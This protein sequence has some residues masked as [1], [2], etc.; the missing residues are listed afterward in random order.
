M[1]PGALM[2][3]LVRRVL[4]LLC[5][6]LV[7]FIAPAAIAQPS[8]PD[9]P[10]DVEESVPEDVDEDAPDEDSR[11]DG[12]ARL[13]DAGEPDLPEAPR[14]PEAVDEPDSEDR[15]IMAD[16]N[17]PPGANDPCDEE[18]P[19]RPVV[20]VHGTFE[21]AQSSWS[22]LTPVL[23]RAEYCVFT[24]DYGENERGFQGTEEIED[25]AAELEDFIEGD[26]GVLDRTG[27]DEVQIVGHSQGGLMPR[28]YVKELGG[29]DVVDD[30]IG[31][32]SSNHG[33]DNPFAPPAG[34]LGG[35]PACDQ[36]FPYQFSDDGNEFTEE[37]NTG[38]ETP[39]DVSYTQI[40]SRFDEIILPYFSTF[41][42]DEDAGDEPPAN[43]PLTAELDGDGTT[44]VCL[45]DMFPNN[46]T[47]HQATQ[48]DPQTFSVVLNALGQEGP[49]DK[50]PAAQQDK[51]CAASAGEA[52]DGDGTGQ[53]GGSD[54]GGNGSGG[55]GNGN[56]SGGS[57]PTPAP[58][59][60]VFSAEAFAYAQ[61][62]SLDLASNFRGMANLGRLGRC[63]AVTVDVLASGTTP[64]AGCRKQRLS[65]VRG[66]KRRSDFRAC[67]LAASRA[68]VARR[69]AGF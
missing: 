29:E 12:P 37:L 17:P 40:A 61:C 1:Y 11:G 33:T 60:P 19:D 36:Q 66:K 64:A 2:S 20:L 53:S 48:F 31:L 57:N 44:N 13:P 10:G 46:T 28:Y 39:G 50:V 15:S 30:L 3:P 9:L 63:M 23:E 49:A 56:G 5:L 43:G 24:I 35:C 55:G 32:N 14:L 42:E 67:V 65:T 7:A 69:L 59:R 45:Q 47:D 4:F 68:V 8:I 22:A 41:L 58:F 16:Q 21:T 6:V 38:D 25:S 18:D 34:D 62:M 51:V 52:P 54:R 26:G 27:A